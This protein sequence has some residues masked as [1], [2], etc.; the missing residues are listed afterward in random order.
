MKRA[1]AALF[2]AQ[3][4]AGVSLAQ[5][6]GTAEFGRATGGEMQLAVKTPKSTSATLG[7]D[8]GTSAKGYGATFGG[9]LVP[10]RIWF[11]ASA[12]RNESSW[13]GGQSELLAGKADAQLGDRQTL[14]LS[15]G[16][17]GLKPAAASPIEIPSTFLDLR[18][19]GIVSNNMFFTVN[20]SRSQTSR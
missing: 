1:L 4:V 6:T 17:S 12:Q 9:T 3:I 15:A 8:F 18:Y 16:D 5:E 14:T 13:F 10:D 7:F 19:T 20:V 2:A 11:F